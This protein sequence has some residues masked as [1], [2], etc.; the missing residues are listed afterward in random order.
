[1]IVVAVGTFAHGFD[2]LVE[3]ADRAIA[4]LGAVGFAQVGHGRYLPVAMSWARFL[5]APAF[6]ARLREASI[7]VCHGGIGIIGEAMR[8]G[9]PIVAVPRRGPTTRRHPA[10][11][12]SAF[13]HRLAD[14][15]PI[16]VCD[17]PADI[18]IALRRRLALAPPRYEL[19]SDIPDLVAR[20]L[21]GSGER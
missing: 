17:D 16:T 10:N 11:D 6:L 14:R 5:P 3:G 9:R 4:T 12:Q 18:T 21:A 15:L 2:E 8:V 1:M 19:D 7:V 13:L 20:Y